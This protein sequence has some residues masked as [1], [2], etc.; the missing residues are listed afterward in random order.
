MNDAELDRLLKSAPVPPRPEGYWAEFP[1]R[2]AREAR[3][4]PTCETT[5]PGNRW[6]PRLAW[7][8]GLATAC[9]IAGFWLG[10]R[11]PTTDS[12]ALLQN[13]KLISEV[14]A[15]FPNRVH[16][17]VQDER[18]LRLELADEADLPNSTPLWVQF[19]QGGQTS[20]FV[21]FSGQ[22]VEV[23]GQKLTVLAG[24]QDRVLVIGDRFVWSTEERQSAPGQFQ[25]E[26][27]PL[28]LVAVK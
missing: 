16:A 25:V 18:G 23:A 2:V 9:L 1:E 27:K 20:S 17:I 14:L 15:L 28:N 10:H 22:Q 8:L 24:G 3:R 7:G 13:P 5:V 19:R 11:Q 4:P 6:L 12:A 21:T 26:A